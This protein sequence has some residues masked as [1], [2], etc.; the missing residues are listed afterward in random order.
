MLSTV[1]STFRVELDP[2]LDPEDF[3][4]YV[5]SSEQKGT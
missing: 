4:S 1:F 3:D 5:S 2:G